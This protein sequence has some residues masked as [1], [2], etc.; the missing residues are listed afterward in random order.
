[1][2]RNI[3]YNKGSEKKV[4]QEIPIKVYKSELFSLVQERG[5]FCPCAAVCPAKSQLFW[6][7][8]WE[9][10]MNSLTL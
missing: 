9:M 8:R 5:K 6:G 3:L 2:L 4:Y 10:C 7:V 1:M